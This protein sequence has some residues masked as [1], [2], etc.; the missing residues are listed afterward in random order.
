LKTKPEAKAS[1]CFI[2]GNSLFS[3]TAL[4]T[5]HENNI[6]ITE[7]VLAGHAPAAQPTSVL[8]VTTNAETD[9]VQQFAATHELPV[10]YLGHR[11]N[12]QQQWQTICA[13]NARHPRPDYVF[14]AC[15]AEKLPVVVLQWPQYQCVNLHPSLLP[16]Y[17]G[18]DPLFWQL[19]NNE[20]HTGFSLHELTDELDAGAILY[21]QDVSLPRDASYEELNALLA[22]LGAQ[23]FARLI[24]TQTLHPTPQDHSQA[25][26]YPFPT[27]DDYRIDAHWSA[28]HAFR[29]IRGTQTPDGGYPVS[30]GNTTLYLTEA[31]SF[32]NNESLTEAFKYKNDSVRIRFADGVLQAKYV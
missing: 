27:A 26:Y 16:K 11:K 12:R 20:S 19:R 28:A 15:F 32:N 24:T 17:R 31:L 25:S 6:N 23:A 13:D 1:V 10:T 30:L 9:S 7:I 8:P 21:Q 18:P 29:F 22:R 4:R 5:L 14:V 3:F 2:G